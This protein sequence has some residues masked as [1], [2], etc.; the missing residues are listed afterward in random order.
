MRSHVDRLA[1][2]LT[3]HS[4][5]SKRVDFV[6]RQTGRLLVRGDIGNV[7]DCNSVLCR[8]EQAF[9]CT[10]TFS[11]ARSCGRFGRNTHRKNAHQAIDLPG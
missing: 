3:G 5:D 6:Y 2:D 9:E 8:S 11:T 10:R 1:F 7:W 4:G